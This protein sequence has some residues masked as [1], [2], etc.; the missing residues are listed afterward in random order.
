MVNVH[1]CMPLMQHDLWTY[2][3]LFLLLQ[4]LKV[5]L[6]LFSK[7]L[8]LTNTEKSERKRTTTNNKNIDT[9]HINNV[10]LILLITI[11][12]RARTN[13]KQEENGCRLIL[14]KVK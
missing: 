11:R 9:D 1:M 2:K 13:K 12:T 10:P 3:P 4:N 5:T 7:C 14:P 6:I 8:C